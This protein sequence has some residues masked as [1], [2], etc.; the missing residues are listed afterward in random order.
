MG[1][2]KVVILVGKYADDDYK[3]VKVDADGKVV[4]TE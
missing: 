3:L 4:T 2:C 1:R